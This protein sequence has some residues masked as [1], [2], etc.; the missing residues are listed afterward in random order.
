MYDALTVN[1]L[2]VKYSG[3]IV[4]FVSAGCSVFHVLCSAFC[5]YI[6]IYSRFFF[7]S[8]ICMLM[9]YSFISQAQTMEMMYRV[10]AQ[11]LCQ[12][13]GRSVCS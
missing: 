2:V 8:V 9:V 7:Y 10:I 13:L 4:M 6:P 5:V 3:S 1:V 11:E 12:C